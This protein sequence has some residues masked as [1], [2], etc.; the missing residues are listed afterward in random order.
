M[1]VSP[2]FNCV[3]EFFWPVLVFIFIFVFVFIFIFVFIFDSVFDLLDEG[4]Q[5]PANC[6]GLAFVL[7]LP[8]GAWKY[9]A[10][11]NFEHHLFYG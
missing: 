8:I 3:G 2:L 6:V 11:Q 7:T 9:L 1:A 10:V 5:G 4:F